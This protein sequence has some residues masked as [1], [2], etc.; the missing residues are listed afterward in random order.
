[1]K[2]L[3]FLVFIKQAFIERQTMIPTTQDN[4]LYT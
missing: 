1:M 4:Y 3:F 2:V